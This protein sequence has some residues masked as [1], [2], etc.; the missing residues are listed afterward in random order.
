MTTSTERRPARG[1]LETGELAVDVRTTPE[2]RSH[3][4]P[5]SVHT[6]LSDL[7]A[8]VDTLS[9]RAQGERLVL[10]CRTGRR[11]EEARRRLAEK[12]IEATVLEGG[13]E[14]W[15]A[16]GG[17]CSSGG[18]GMSI[19]RQVRVAAGALVVLGVALGFLVHPALFGLSAFVGAGLVFAG[20]TDTCGMAMV[21]ARLPFNRKSCAR[22]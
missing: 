15:L 14:A 19:E 21:L 16:A 13:I 5:D 9:R 8:Y 3:H 20:L 22:P 2:F 10:V 6:P 7:D 1:R 12:G 4:V 17:P 11:A 18:R